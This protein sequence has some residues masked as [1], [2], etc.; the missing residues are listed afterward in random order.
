M[1]NDQRIAMR[2]QPL[3]PCESLALGRDYAFRATGMTFGQFI[4]TY[5]VCVASF[6]VFILR[7]CV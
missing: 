7:L 2:V 5:T 6:A 3:S 4:A 1:E